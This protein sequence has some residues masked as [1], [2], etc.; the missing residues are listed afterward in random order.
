MSIFTNLNLLTPIGDY[1]GLTLVNPGSFRQDRATQEAALYL[2]SSNDN[3]C[4]LYRVNLFNQAVTRVTQNSLVFKKVLGLCYDPLYDQL[5]L[6]DKDY[7]NQIFYIDYTT[8][9]VVN[10][11][12]NNYGITSVIPGG[13]E[14]PYQRESG[15]GLTYFN[16]NKP[17][18]NINFNNN[19]EV[20]NLRTSLLYYTYYTFGS[21]F[22]PPE[23]NYSFLVSSHPPANENILLF[24]TIKS[25]LFN[26]SLPSSFATDLNNPKDIYRAIA[27]QIYVLDRS[28]LRIKKQ[29]K[30]TNQN[31]LTF[32]VF[33]N[34]FYVVNVNSNTIDVY[35]IS[36]DKKLSKL[37]TYAEDYRIKP[38]SSTKFI[39]EVSDDQYTP[40]K[41]ISMSARILV[42]QETNTI[43]TGCQLNQTAP[44][45]LNLIPDNLIIRDPLSFENLDNLNFNKNNFALILDKGEEITVQDNMLALQPI[46]I[47]DPNLG[48]TLALEN[49][50]TADL[51]GSSFD[52]DNRFFTF[53]TPQVEEDYLIVNFNELKYLQYIK[54]IIEKNNTDNLFIYDS[55]DNLI[56]ETNTLYPGLF[57]TLE[58]KNFINKTEVLTS[59]IKIQTSL[60]TK[61]YDV[62]IKVSV[63]ENYGKFLLADKTSDLQGSAFF[64]YNVFDKNGFELVKIAAQNKVLDINT[65]SLLDNSAVYSDLI[66][67]EINNRKVS[68]SI[69]L[70]LKNPQTSF[71]YATMRLVEPPPP[72]PVDMLAGDIQY[73]DIPVSA[74]ANIIDSG[75]Y[76]KSITVSNNLVWVLSQ[77]GNASV[78]ST[79]PSAEDL[80]FVVSPRQQSIGAQSTNITITAPQNYTFTNTTQL[81]FGP[82]IVINSIKILEKDINDRDRL[83]ANITISDITTSGTRDI[84]I[85][86]GSNRPVTL[87]NR[88]EIL[89]QTLVAVSPVNYVAESP[90][91]PRFKTIFI[92]SASLTGSVSYG[93]FIF[94][95]DDKGY[96]TRSTK[97]FDIEKEKITTASIMNVCLN[98]NDLIVG[99]Q[100]GIFYKVSN[101]QDFNQFKP[102]LTQIGTIA[103][104]LL[105]FIIKDGFIIATSKLATYLELINI[106]TGT[107]TVT[108]NLISNNI[109]NIF[110]KNEEI[111][112]TDDFGSLYLIDINGLIQ[113]S[114]FIPS[115]DKVV[116]IEIINNSWFIA[117]EK[118]HI[119]RYSGGVLEKY[120]SYY[121]VGGFLTLSKYFNT[122]QI[123]T[124]YG[125]YI[126]L[127]VED[128]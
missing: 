105:N 112:I 45:I 92:N 40:L 28:T 102:I 77:G 68:S 103:R 53:W 59:F 81:D 104:P 29:I 95:V 114:V 98:Q 21:T 72:R 65:T 5:I 54:L 1:A 24:K 96:L 76:I 38:G 91:N 109:T 69:T 30:I 90:V 19:V 43:E 17:L 44:L 4:H 100:Q 82:G 125:R 115:Q 31:I 57:T 70:N 10:E 58:I 11:V 26:Q 64:E 93:P 35:D 62:S 113:A 123:G 122:L 34:K 79:D 55:S 67:L 63:N 6:T 110:L 9:Q 60:N 87:N 7:P 78:I 52:T 36:A 71:S 27:G 118:C 117:T 121:D 88:F 33:N 124:E 107:R 97:D 3:S 8:G 106:S 12:F 75:S 116:G 50:F 14:Y 89:P 49:Y 41:D 15:L 80:D 99:T 74:N 2:I 84:K 66:N 22:F 119:Y 73:P 47:Q 32:A 127:E 37:I 83:V 61:I 128:A 126:T 48:N 85:T 23:N 56:F 25:N 108:G 13:S 94:I 46:S 39:G 111:F 16:L 42:D 51:S 120:Q 101:V 86:S 18:K 20:E